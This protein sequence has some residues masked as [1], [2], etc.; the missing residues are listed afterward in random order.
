[1]TYREVL[2]ILRHRGNEV[3]GIHLGLQR[4]RAMM[5]ALG[6]PQFHMPVVHIAGTNGKG[7]VAAMVESILRHAGCRTGLYT[8]PHL[9]RLE[10]RIRVSGALISRRELT[11]AV[12]RVIQMEKSLLKRRRL[13]RPLTYFEILTAC[14][15]VHFAR[16]RIDAAVI[17]VGL[18]GRLDATNVVD[19]AVCVITGVAHDH[20][21]LLGDRLENIARE[22]AGIIKPAVPVISACKSGIARRVI[23]EVARLKRAPLVE[24]DRD[25][26]FR[27]VDLQRGRITMDLQTPRRA[28]RNLR[29]SLAGR[30]QTRNAALAVT[31]VET[32]SEFAVEPAAVSRGL[33]AVRWP[34]RLEEYRARRRTLLDGAHNPEGARL[35]AGHLGEFGPPQI[36]I[37]FAAMRDKD[38]RKMGNALFPLA[39]SIHLA[40]LINPRAAAPEEIAAIHHRFR[41]RM[42]VHRN[43]TDALD[44][45]WK[46]CPRDGLVVVT[47]SLYLVGELLPQLRRVT[48]HSAGTRPS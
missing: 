18:G 31:A 29:L 3:Q 47:G 9:I 23:R 46:A 38:I 10:E 5:D 39:R 6:N 12:S 48:R 20:Q 8:S 16:C 27:V 26:S 2:E 33:N 17:E 37:V 28:Y 25:C 41:C 44:A 43:S 15:F 42:Q 36:H 22:K 19:P 14:A 11:K 32:V 35:L 21:D 34:G 24:I 1:M 40:P 45:A 30:H 13:N 7:S 4:M